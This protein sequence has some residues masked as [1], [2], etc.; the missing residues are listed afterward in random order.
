MYADH[1]LTCW[2]IK[3]DV[4]HDARCIQSQHMENV[5]NLSPMSLL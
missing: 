4:K 5:F 3:T 1:I 2:L